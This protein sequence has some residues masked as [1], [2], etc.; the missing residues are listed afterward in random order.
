MKN[1]ILK[2]LN[3]QKRK[4]NILL[5]C[6]LIISSLV[7]IGTTI[8]Y[9]LLTNKNEVDNNFKIGDYNIIPNENFNPPTHWKKGETI[10]KEVWVENKG[11][12][13]VYIRVRVQPYWTNGLPLIVND[14]NTIKLNF[15]N[16]ND[17]IKKDNFYY[18]KDILK[19]NQKTSNL[20]KSVTLNK[21]I[22]DYYKKQEFN[23]DV[24]VESIQ[25]K[26]KEALKEVWKLDKI[27]N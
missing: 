21:N 7:L 19:P 25:A 4:K 20:L 11:N 22:L 24:I 8:T 3:K 18:Y 23:V 2:I 15:S 9:A 6:F 1:N 26:P 17:W 5:F 27:P 10:K 13:D 16:N 12:I 14:K